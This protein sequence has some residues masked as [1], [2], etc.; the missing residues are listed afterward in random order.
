MIREDDCTALQEN[1]LYVE[2]KIRYFPQC[3]DFL[4][5][6]HALSRAPYRSCLPFSLPVGNSSIISSVFAK[7]ALEMGKV[8]CSED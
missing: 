3:D 4:V 2:T 8:V 5:S 6:F 7:E 1:Q